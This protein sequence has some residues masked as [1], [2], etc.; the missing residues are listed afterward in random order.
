ME[1]S[2][3][4]GSQFFATTGC[5]SPTIASSAPTF[6]Q[7]YATG[8][9]S[10]APFNLAAFRPPSTAFLGAHTHLKDQYATVPST[11]PEVN[12]NIREVS[13]SADIPGNRSADEE[14]FGEDDDS[15][16]IDGYDEENNNFNSSAKLVNHHLAR[17][18]PCSAGY[19]GFHTYPYAYPEEIGREV[20]ASDYRDESPMKNCDSERNR[21]SFSE[22][23]HFSA[24]RYLHQQQGQ[25]NSPPRRHSLEV[26]F[27]KGYPPAK[28]SQPARPESPENLSSESKGRDLLDFS[29]RQNHSN[30][31]EH[32]LPFNFLGPPLAA[33]HSMTEMKSSLGG[34]A[35]G[36]SNNNSTSAPSMSSPNAGLTAQ[37]M[38]GQANAP[39]PHGIDTILSRP[40][41]VTSAGLSSL[42]AG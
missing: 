9:P 3:N 41:P 8:F 28:N 22:L 24:F 2:L 27:S 12:N 5:D 38:H 17:T 20:S 6:A 18:D 42:T 36:D 31:L 30:M 34:T 11:G 4:L 33:L 23:G 37:T 35:G 21:G 10:Y 19:S 40:P 25:E 13:D 7:P 16:N 26:N 1:A 29:A 32:K 15:V 14:E 39:N